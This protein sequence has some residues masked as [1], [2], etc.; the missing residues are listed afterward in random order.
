[1]NN[2]QKIQNKFGRDP[3]FKV[4][5]GFL[6][7][8][9]VEVRDKRHQLPHVESPKVTRWHR[10]RPYIYLAAMFAGIW[11][12]MKVFTTASDNSIQS[13]PLAMDQ[14]VESVSLENPPELI[15][16]AVVNPEV[17][18]EMQYA[19]SVSTSTATTDYEL[20]QDMSQSYSDFNQFEQ[21]FDYQFNDEYADINVDEVIARVETEATNEKEEE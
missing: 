18:E 2:E 17:I 7:K 1:M 6:D 8:V 11:C 15:A 5:E 3:G 21:D 16:R 9:Y 19:E 4:P 10:I 12:M 13:R 14:S 20:E